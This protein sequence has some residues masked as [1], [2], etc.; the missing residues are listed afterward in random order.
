LSKERGDIRND[1]ESHGRVVSGITVRSGKGCGLGMI[2]FAVGPLSE[3]VAC[4]FY[5]FA[6]TCSRHDFEAAEYPFSPVRLK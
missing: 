1:R 6:K 4:N 5:Q 3:T 2:R